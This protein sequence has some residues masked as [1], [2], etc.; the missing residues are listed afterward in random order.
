LSKLIL[1]YKNKTSSMSG[2]LVTCITDSPDFVTH[3]AWLSRNDLRDHLA[4]VLPLSVHSTP[5]LTN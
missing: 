1:L 4:N 3:S 5:L 2:I